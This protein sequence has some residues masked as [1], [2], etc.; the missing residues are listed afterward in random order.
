MFDAISNMQSRSTVTSP[1][2]T[3]EM[4]T[5]CCK[6]LSSLHVLKFNAVV[7]TSASMVQG[8]LAKSLTR[9]LLPLPISSFSHNA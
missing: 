7:L 5:Y 9:P 6:A 3:S 8:L 2:H 1:Q 4:L